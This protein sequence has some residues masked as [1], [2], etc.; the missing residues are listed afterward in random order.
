MTRRDCSFRVTP[1]TTQRALILASL[2][3]VERT[4]ALGR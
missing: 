3:P 4:T 2:R 1:Y